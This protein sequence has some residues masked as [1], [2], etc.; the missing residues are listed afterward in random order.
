MRIGELSRLAG[1]STRML[2]HYDAIGLVSPT[3]RSANGYRDYTPDDIRRLFRVESL[4]TLGLSLQSI[5]HT[6]ADADVA[7]SELVEELIASTGERIAREQ[8]LLRRLEGVRASG[9]TSWRDVLDL[10]ALMQG[11]DSSDPSRRQRAALS[12]GTPVPAAPI[13][14]ALL[15]EDDPNVAGAL[16]WALTRSSDD[17]LP[18][19]VEALH[20]SDEQARRQAVAALVKLEPADSESALR[21]ALGH[22]DRVVRER[23][24]LALGSRGAVEVVPELLEMVVRGSDD[25]VAAEILGRLARLHGLGDQLAGVVVARLASEDA[26]PGARARLTQALAEIP[27]P[28]AHHALADLTQDR[29]RAVAVTATYLLAIH[30]ATR[31]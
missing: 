6:L 9:A 17:A 15:E 30:S 12:D 4:R 28:E 26:L 29:D 3:S 2:R 7:P 20:S 18:H 1:I 11:L 13:V 5:R 23:A 25:V 21:D 22:T 31:H 24:S 16:Q 8:A 14:D 19:L 10:V 27:G